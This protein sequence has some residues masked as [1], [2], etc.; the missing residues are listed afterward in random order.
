MR[1]F[2]SFTYESSMQN[3]TISLE[4]LFGRNGAPTDARYA[5]MLIYYRV[6]HTGKTAGAHGQSQNLVHLVLS[7]EPD[8]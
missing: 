6:F 2:I 4:L 3:L 8:A 7:L 1:T 5:L